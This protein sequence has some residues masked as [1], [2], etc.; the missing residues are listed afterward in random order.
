MIAEIRTII[1]KKVNEVYLYRKIS[2]GHY[3]L[4]TG[5]SSTKNFNFYSV[6]HFRRLM[7]AAKFHFLWFLFATKFKKNSR[8]TFAEDFICDGFYSPQSSILYLVLHLFV[9]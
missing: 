5:P 4:A 8:L 2:H 6:L 1:N 7:I 9:V 3:A